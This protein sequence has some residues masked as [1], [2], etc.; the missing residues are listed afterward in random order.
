MLLFHY[1]WLVH[2]DDYDDD[3]DEVADM[4]TPGVIV[5]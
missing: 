3:D 2:S 5:W 4:M 1:D